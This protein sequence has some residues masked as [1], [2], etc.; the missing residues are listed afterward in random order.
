M[1]SVITPRLSWVDLKWIREMTSLPLVLKGIQTVEDAIL[2]YQHGVAG[3]VLS[4]HGGRS[5][6]TTQPSLLTLLEIR[7]HA[8]F[9]IGGKMEIYLDGGIRRGRDVIKALALGATAV[10]LG[11]PFLYSLCGYGELGVRRMVSILRDEVV[12]NMALAGVR[13]IQEITPDLVNASK[14]QRDLLS[15][16]RL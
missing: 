8:P 12:T 11:R 13:Q 10:G 15:S 16:A 5:Q 3:I 1:S 14:L 2:A 7:K 9:L 6:D 4:N